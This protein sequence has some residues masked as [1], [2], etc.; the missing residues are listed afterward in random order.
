MYIPGIS[1]WRYIMYILGIYQ[2]YQHLFQTRFFSS[3]LLLVSVNEQIL[4]VIKRDLFHKRPGQPG[5]GRRWPTKGSRRP[6]LHVFVARTPLAVAGD[7][8]GGGC[9]AGILFLELQQSTTWILVR[10]GAEGA[11]RAG[12]KCGKQ[13]RCIPALKIKIYLKSICNGG[14]S[15]TFKEPE[16]LNW[17]FIASL[18][19]SELFFS[20]EQQTANTRHYHEKLEY[21]IS[22]E[23]IKM[24]FKLRSWLM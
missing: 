12:D 23:L 7:S 3:P 16:R 1:P 18:M 6:P 14:R 4:W 9:I 17:L 5:Q 11:L 2:V 15:C 20:S 24:N 22:S 21:S 8:W 10:D 13:H 19:N